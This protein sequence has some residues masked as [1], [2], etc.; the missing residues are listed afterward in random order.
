M[1]DGPSTSNAAKR[2]GFLEPSTK[3]RVPAS[4][5]YCDLCQVCQTQY[6]THLRTNKR[7][8]KAA[9]FLKENVFITSLSTS[10]NVVQYKNVSNLRDEI[11]IDTCLDGN[12]TYMHEQIQIK[13]DGFGSV[14][15]NLRL[16]KPKLIAMKIEEILKDIEFSCRTELQEYRNIR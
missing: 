6:K 2:K 9:V 1:N 3:T 10:E 11:S 4:E 16:S 14:K 5:V 13:L 15:F 8:E 7:N 12:P